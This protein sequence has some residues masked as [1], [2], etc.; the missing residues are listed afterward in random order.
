MAEEFESEQEKTEDP[1][2]NRI[3]EFR[4]HGEVA[5]S[6]ELVSVLVL[7]SAILTIILGIVYI[8]ETMSEFVKWLYNLDIE[9][10]FT[11]KSFRTIV[12][13]TVMTS[14]K[15]FAPV[16]VVTFAVGVFANV[17]QIGFLFSPDVLQFKL[18]RIDP[19]RGVKKLFSIRSFVEALKGLAKF[20]FILTIVYFFIRNDL[21]TYQ[22]FLNV[23]FAEGV[24]HAR[25][26][27][28][29]LAFA[30]ILGLLVIAIGDF[31]YQKISYR[32][33]LMMTKEQ[34]KKESR[35][36]EGNPEIKQRIKAIQ[37]EMATKR[38]MDDVK[39]S[40]VVVTNPIHI[41]VALKYDHETMSSPKVVAKGADNLAMRIRKVA[42]AHDVPM[43]ENVSLAR[44]M[45]KTIKIGQFVPRN[46][47]QAV[48]QVL[49]YVY[50]LKG[51]TLQQQ[52]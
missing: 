17:I 22:G 15:C 49:S 39:T 30:I 29:E 11:E 37:R 21:T 25:W 35:E 7:S 38:M 44:V 32:N 31:S 2:S 40:D 13:K 36:K 9:T 50:K 33:K 41:S 6:K 12:Y 16:A 23:G 42:K 34:V 46:L 4:R 47:Y 51:K 27:I 3:E 19:I 18:E 14:L 45:Y 52:V 43:V 26:L 10:A 24:F 48:S 1:S 8:S 20:L 28:A 5:S